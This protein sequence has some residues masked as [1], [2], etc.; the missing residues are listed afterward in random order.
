[1]TIARATEWLREHAALVV[2]IIVVLLLTALPYVEA[3]M[4]TG[5]SW[6]GILPPFT[7]GLNEARIHV[8]G[9]GHLSD[10]N[11]Y[12]KEHADGLPLVIFGG[13]WLNALPLWLGLSFNATYFLNFA[14][15]SVLFALTAYWLLRALYLRTWVAAVAAFVLYLQSYGHVIRPANLQPVYPFFFLFYLALW[16]FIQVQKRSTIIFLGLCTGASF[17]LYA[18]FWQGV[19]IT[20]GLLFFWSVLKKNWL[21]SKAT[22]LASGLGGAIGVP[23]PLYMLYLSHS[24]PFYWESMRRLGLVDTHLPTSE[25]VYSGGWVGIVLILLAVLYW[26]SPRL[27][28]DTKWKELSLYAVLSGLALWILEGSNLLTG[29]WV[30]T[31]EHVRLFITAWLLFVSVALG[32]A[33]WKRRQTL[34]RYVQLFAMGMFCLLALANAYFTYTT[35]RPYLAVEG[36]RDTWVQWESY[37]PVF[38]WLNH[39]GKRGEVVWSDPHDGFGS[40]LVLNTHDFSLYTFWGQLELVPD[41]EIYERYLITQ[42]FN[43]PTV[44]TLSSDAEASLYLGRG[45]FPHKAKTVQRKVQLCRILFFWNKQNCGTIP[46][47]QSLKGEAFFTA[48]ATK[49]TSDIKPNI[50]AYLSKYHV[51]YI[52]K[53]T[54]LDPHWQPQVL[55]AK[56][57]W[58]DERYEIY[59]LQ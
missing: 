29:K 31:G 18:F 53:D 9:E 41:E 51:R 26:Y 25:V 47:P 10:G 57:V 35:F 34:S 13:A 49:F 45:D 48:L 30:E 33:V 2:L 54:T 5:D 52:V 37:A 59:Q 24:S 12:F 46:T 58:H 4:L 40:A 20:L 38:D 28:S 1:M 42:Y 23:V 22:L 19:V 55:G 15:W 8:I 44:E 43:N 11:A 6:R 32:V 56:E 36:N 39:N 7:D 50:Q 3:R 27:W 14:I 21:L 17:Y 16:W